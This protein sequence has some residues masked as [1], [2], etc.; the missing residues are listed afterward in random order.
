[1]D[2][3]QMSTEGQCG[4]TGG[5]WLAGL[6]SQPSW[7][8]NSAGCQP[9]PLP[10]MD[11][12]FPLGTK[13]QLMD[14]TWHLGA[15]APPWRGGQPGVR[16]A[17]PH[18][19]EGSCRAATQTYWLPRKRPWLF[20]PCVSLQG[21]RL[22]SPDSLLAVERAGALETASPGWNPGSTSV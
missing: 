17:S 9:H 3:K 4:A 1:M 5:P 21:S 15:T 20:L 18:R 7:S 11:L 22:P 16:C 19:V 12:R 6:L 8:I 2:P 13:R 14:G 10:K